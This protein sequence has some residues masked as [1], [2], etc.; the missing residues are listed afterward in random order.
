VVERDVTYGNIVADPRP[1][2]SEVTEND[3]DAVVYSDLQI[4]GVPSHTV[5]PSGD[6]YANISK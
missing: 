5:A 3:N 6:L 1:R 2:S 4:T